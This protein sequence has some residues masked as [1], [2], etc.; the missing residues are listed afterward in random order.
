M[1][2]LKEKILADLGKGIKELHLLQKEQENLYHI[3]PLSFWQA[4]S[5]VAQEQARAVK[6]FV[7]NYPDKEHVFPPAIKVAMDYLTEIFDTAEN[8]IIAYSAGKPIRN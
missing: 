3:W 4:V 1:N 2:H 5:E 7:D 8:L 6:D